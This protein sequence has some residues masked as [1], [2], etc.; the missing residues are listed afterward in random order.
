M[1]P[2]VI[3]LAI[4]SAR[5]SEHQHRVGA[6]IFKK[7]NIISSAYN[8]AFSYHSNLHPKYQNYFG[9]VHAEVAAIIAAKRD[10]KNCE[11][12]V[13]R[14]NK[15]GELKL[16]LPCDYCMSYVID[17]GIKKVTY[18]DNDSNFCTIRIRK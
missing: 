10:L 14:I 16:S 5:Q 4:E 13:V 7:K 6:V 9:S 1:S 17:V 3:E 12:C 2:K 8:K 18:T 15:K 11:I